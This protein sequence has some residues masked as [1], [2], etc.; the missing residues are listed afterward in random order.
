MRK[1]VLSLLVGLS[2][3]AVVIFFFYNKSEQR[4]PV[5]TFTLL[6]EA[7]TQWY[8][9]GIQHYRIVVE[10]EFSTER[11]RHAATVQNGQII[12]ATLS[13]WDGK[14]W[15]T[16]ETASLD[17]ADDY[18]IPGLF[19]T[20]R[21]ELNNDIREDLRVDMHDDPAYPRYMYFG[22]VW[23]ENEPMDDSLAHFTVVEFEPFTP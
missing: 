14:T 8:T 18:I 17:S 19:T 13:Y 15:S 12:E 16:P 10:V 9:A 2:L 22:R 3:L 1:I 23:L 11:R 5:A 7:E 4:Y 6:N 21:G 20:L